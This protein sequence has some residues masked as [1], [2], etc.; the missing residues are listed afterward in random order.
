[1][2]LTALENGAVTH[3]TIAAPTFDHTCDVLVIGAGSAGAYAADSAAREGA[4]VILCEIAEK[5]R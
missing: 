4:S 5:R 2:I 3:K 1:M